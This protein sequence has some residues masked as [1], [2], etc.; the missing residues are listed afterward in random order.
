MSAVVVVLGVIGLCLLAYAGRK[1]VQQ[2]DWWHTVERK[3]MLVR[4]EITARPWWKD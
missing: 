2:P 1:L 4:A 3:Q